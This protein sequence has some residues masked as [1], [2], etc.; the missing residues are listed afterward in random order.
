MFVSK[1]TLTLIFS[2]IFFNLFCFSQARIVWQKKLSFSPK[3]AI[4]TENGALYVC[5]FSDVCLLDSSGNILWQKKIKDQSQ[6][7]FYL[8]DQGGLFTATTKEKLI[9]FSK[10][11]DIV[12][13]KPFKY[14]NIIGQGNNKSTVFAT[15]GG[16]LKSIYG[17][18]IVVDQKVACIDSTGKTVWTYF[19]KNEQIPWAYQLKNGNIMVAVKKEGESGDPKIFLINQHGKFIKETNIKA[20]KTPVFAGDLVL[21]FTLDPKTYFYK[22]VAYSA[23]LSEKKWE[24]KTGTTKVF[25]TLYRNT[26]YWVMPEGA[27]IPEYGT[28][29]MYNL[30]GKMQGSIPKVVYMSAQGLVIKNKLLIP[31]YGRLFLYESPFDIKE[32]GFA[33]G[34][35]N[36]F[37]AGKD[38]FY[39]LNPDKKLVIAATL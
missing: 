24:V 10:E 1:K 36:S 28:M 19:T 35:A 38:R 16:H 21:L 8:N 23:D 12:V 30:N 4:E 39:V 18:T 17:G 6:G 34:P 11:G 5:S 22:L 15:I 13:N 3:K 20:A 9:V 33:A 26:L 27:M 25:P 7:K 14:L 29:V 31:R 37:F 2:I 32:I